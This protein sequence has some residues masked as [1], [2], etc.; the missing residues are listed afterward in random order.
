M[1]LSANRPFELR[2]YRIFDRSP[3]VARP[4]GLALEDHRG[5]QQV[6]GADG[7]ARLGRRRTG[8]GSP[9]RRRLPLAAAAV[10]RGEPLV[11]RA[12]PQP[13]MK[14]AAMAT[15]VVLRVFAT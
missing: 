7:D 4:R 10:D 15:Q 6:A 12:A 14:A 3:V 13:G 2:Q 9:A 11:A 1:R 8:R 5:S